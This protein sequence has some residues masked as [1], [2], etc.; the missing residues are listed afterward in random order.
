MD[1]F[2]GALM[3]L[4]I[5][6]L[7]YERVPNQYWFMCDKHMAGIRKWVEQRPENVKGNYLVWDVY[8]DQIYPFKIPCHVCWTG[9]DEEMKLFRLGICKGATPEQII[10]GE[11][12]AKEL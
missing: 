12:E 10:N 11:G 3:R 7:Y 5:G 1:G 8:E 6:L 4:L 9:F 2:Y